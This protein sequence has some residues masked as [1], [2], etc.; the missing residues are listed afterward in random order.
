VTLTFQENVE[1]GTLTLGGG[2][3]QLDNG[4]GFSDTMFSSMLAPSLSSTMQ[5]HGVTLT[6]ADNV[7]TIAWNPNVGLSTKGPSDVIRS[8]T[9]SAS[10]LSATSLQ[11][12]KHPELRVSLATLLAN[13]LGQ[14]SPITCAAP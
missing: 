13:V 8:V 9:Y 10:S 6:F 1:D 5:E 7:A 3:E 12:V 4:L 14:F 2:A 11:P